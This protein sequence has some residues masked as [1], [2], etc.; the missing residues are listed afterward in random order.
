MEAELA[1]VVGRVLGATGLIIE[2][3]GPKAKMNELCY[4]CG[5]GQEIPAEV[6]GFRDEKV[7]LMPLSEVEGL[8]PGWQVHGTGGPLRAPTGL[9]LLG[10]VLDGLGQPMDGLGPIG[11]CRHRPVTG[12]PPTPLMRQRI[13]QPLSL[14]VRA[15]DGLLT[16]GQGQRIGIFA[17]SGVGKSTT[18]GMIARA[19]TADANV[20]ALIGERGREV[21][22]FIERDLGPEGLQR[23]VVVVATSEQPA[24]VRIRA[25]LVATAIAEEFR[26]L[27]RDVVLM[28]DSV[29]RLAQAQREVGLSVGEP[30]AT[31]GYTPSVFTML[32]RVLERSGTGQVG[33]VTGIYTVLVDGD[34]M[35]EPVADAVRGI[36]DGHVVLSRKLAHAGQFPAIDV[37]QSVSRVMPE[38][39][40]EAHQRAAR[41]FRTLLAS[42]KEAEDL[43]NIGAYQAGS[44]PTVDEAI[45]KVP[46]MKR[47]LMQ[48]VDERSDLDSAT[49]GLFDL[50]GEE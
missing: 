7:L 40:G 39:T 41:K 17:G 34:D 12:L 49:A 46:A 30:P 21:R 22:E 16:V 37:L 15:M 29:T 23:S 19:T 13:K 14:G 36:L 50:C 35:N 45:A 18:L 11:D 1:P 2:S 8:R 20:I 42:Y 27:G 5:D 25:A 47:F 6:V 28:M 10:R 32:P 9:A 48:R 44:N 26:D 3:A 24:L 43:I 4:L 33:S 38:V 31:R